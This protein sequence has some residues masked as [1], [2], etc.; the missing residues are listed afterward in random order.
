MALAREA[1]S[2][3]A[4]IGSFYCG[5]PSRFADLPVPTSEDWEAA[6]G[7]IFPP[8]F[9]RERDRKTGAL[10]FDKPRDLFTGSECP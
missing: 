4:P 2:T 3:Y 5:A 9:K 7:L 8:S 1:H 10:K 6:T